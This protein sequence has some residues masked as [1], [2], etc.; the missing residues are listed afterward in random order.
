MENY[1]DNTKYKMQYFFLLQSQTASRVLL[2][3]IILSF[4]HVAGILGE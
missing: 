1:L 3:G 4:L 2:V